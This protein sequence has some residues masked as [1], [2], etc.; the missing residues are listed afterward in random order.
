MLL[1][2]KKLIKFPQEFSDPVMATQVGAAVVDNMRLLDNLRC[3]FDVNWTVCYLTV[4]RSVC[5]FILSEVPIGL[6]KHPAAAAAAEF[7]TRR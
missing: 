6:D 4:C 3:V 2:N 5:T 1:T 7:V